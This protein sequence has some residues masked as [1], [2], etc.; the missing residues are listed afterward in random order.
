M[1]T[2]LLAVAAFILAAAARAQTDR[3]APGPPHE[4]RLTVGELPPTGFALPSAT[5]GAIR[6]LEAQRGQRPIL[7]LFFRGTW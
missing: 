4:S 1:T 3:L 2:L 7:L 5:D 6:D